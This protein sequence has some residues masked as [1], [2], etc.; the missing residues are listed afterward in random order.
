MPKLTVHGTEID[1]PAGAAV[2]QVCERVGE[3]LR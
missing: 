2:L 1:V 3:G